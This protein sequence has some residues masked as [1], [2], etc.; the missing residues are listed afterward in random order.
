MHR[1]EAGL[2]TNG[3]WS[4]QRCSLPI[5]GELSWA[6]ALRR[7]HYT[8]TSTPTPTPTRMHRK[9]EISDLTAPDRRLETFRARRGSELQ[10]AG[11]ARGGCEAAAEESFWRK[12]HAGVGM[13]MHAEARADASVGLGAR[14]WLRLFTRLARDAQL[15]SPKSAWLVIPDGGLIA[16]D[17]ASAPCG[18]RLALIR[19]EMAIRCRP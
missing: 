17:S 2:P 12:V 10:V 16:D 5:E 11:D 15:R 19:A 14:R 7:S 4:T 1:A 3:V 9:F 6:K 18:L 8:P 13:R